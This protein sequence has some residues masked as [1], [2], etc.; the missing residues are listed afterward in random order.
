MTVDV[1]RIGPAPVRV[2]GHHHRLVSALPS[3]V[4]S[5]PDQEETIS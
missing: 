5:N 3:A 2:G 4:R 1:G